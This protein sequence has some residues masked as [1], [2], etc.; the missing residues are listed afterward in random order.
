MSHSK[1]GRLCR[2]RDSLLLVRVCV[3]ELEEVTDSMCTGEH[4]EFPLKPMNFELMLGFSIFACARKY[5]FSLN[6]LKQS[7]S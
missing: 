6:H 7:G 4:S 2:P 3:I 1:R 5:S